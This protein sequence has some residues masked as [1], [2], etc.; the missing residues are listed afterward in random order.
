MLIAQLVLV[1]LTVKM[2][3]IKCELFPIFL[4]LNAKEEYVFVNHFCVALIG[5]ALLTCVINLC[6]IH[7]LIFIGTM[8]E[9]LE[10]SPIS[11]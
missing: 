4:P 3:Y 6:W 2:L 5:Y 1:F 8:E 7:Y 10:T 9:M 11:E